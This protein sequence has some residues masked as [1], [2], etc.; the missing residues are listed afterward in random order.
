MQPHLG[1]RE[2]ADDMQV[3]PQLE[4]VLVQPVPPLQPQVDAP[5]TL[6]V[7]GF[8]IADPS[9]HLNAQVD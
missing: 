2:P 7:V 3:V 1:H 5:A 8:C 6:P 9:A 4:Q